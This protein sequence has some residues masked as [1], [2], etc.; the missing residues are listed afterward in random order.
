M[1]SPL[2]LPALKTFSLARSCYYFIESLPQALRDRFGSKDYRQIWG[3][4]LRLHEDDLWNIERGH[5]PMSVLLPNWRISEAPAGAMRRL[6]IPPLRIQLRHLERPHILELGCGPASSTVFLAHA[7]PKAR[8][9]AVDFQPAM[10]KEAQEHLQEFPLVDVLQ[11][12]AASLP[13]KDG[14]FDAVTAVFFLQTLRPEIALEVLREARRV[15]KP[16]GTLVVVDAL[17]PADE[18]KYPWAARRASETALP[19][20]SLLRDSGF[21]ETEMTQC[22]FAKVLSARNSPLSRSNAVSI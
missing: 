1:S 3:E 7:L 6:A 4:I 14:L 20:R 12:D 10:V 15:L 18:P 16:G 13:F 8:L 21:V 17:Q 2:M 11:A 22:F 9:T 5:Y 19:L